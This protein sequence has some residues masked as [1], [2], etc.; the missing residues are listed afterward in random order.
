MPGWGWMEKTQDVLSMWVDREEKGTQKLDIIQAGVS[1]K[2]LKAIQKDP[3]SSF[4]RLGP[5][6]NTR[7]KGS[8]AQHSP[9]SPP[10][11]RHIWRATSSSYHHGFFDMVDY[12]N[13][14][15]NKSLLPKVVLWCCVTALR[16]TTNLHWEPR[17][18]QF[19]TF[20]AAVIKLC[21]QNQLNW[22]SLWL[23]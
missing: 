15:Q 2:E 8:W 22:K 18:G 16:K 20:P 10:D 11:C 5:R 13:R 4:Q 14:S 21:W 17:D 7:D 3:P 9:V 12:W 1:I 6:M 23:G 19:I